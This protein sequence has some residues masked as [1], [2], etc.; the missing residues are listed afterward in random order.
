MLFIFNGSNGIHI[1][2]NSTGP[3]TKS[4]PRGLMAGFSRFIR[5]SS[6]G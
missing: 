2:W 1:A 6:A 3:S 4:R 5:T